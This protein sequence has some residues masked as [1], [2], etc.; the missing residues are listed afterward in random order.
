MGVDI[1]KYWYV[2]FV[3]GGYEQTIANKINQ[4]S[5]EVNIEAFLPKVQK[6]F[7]K[8][9][10]VK[11]EE[12]LLFKNYVFVQTDLD[13]IEFSSFLVVNIKSITGFIKLLKHD[14]EGTESL[15]PQEREFL[16]RF[17]NKDKVIEQSIG[18]IEGDR[19]VILQGP[20]AG[21]ESSIVRINRHKRVAVLDISMFGESREVEVGLE[22]ILKT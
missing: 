1:I 7:R 19:V 20:L 16:E 3:L 2:M 12:H 21:Y 4:L 18:F 11:I 15:Y 17:T 14:N 6:A 10:Q 22:I 8:K 9:G 13:H 5:E